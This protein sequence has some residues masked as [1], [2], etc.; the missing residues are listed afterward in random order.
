MTGDGEVEFGVRACDRL[1][2]HY[3][4][5]A[6]CKSALRRHADCGIM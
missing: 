6:S 4:S 5:N 1:R 2:T 3:E